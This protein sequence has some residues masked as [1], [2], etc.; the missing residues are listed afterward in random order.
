MPDPTRPPPLPYARQSLD[1]QDIESVSRIAASPWLTQ[2]PE[3]ECFEKE[4]CGVTGTAFAV[5]TS[6]GTAALHAALQALGVGPG[7]EVLVP[8]L[9]FVGTA[10]AVAACGATPVLVDIDSETLCLDPQAVARASSS[11]TRGVVAVHYGGNPADIDSIRDA[12]P[13]HSFILED[14]CHALGAR[15]RDRPAGS[16]GEAACF[17]F[18]PAKAITSAE[19]GAITSSDP[20][21]IARARRAAQHGIERS[22]EAFEGL[23][24]PAAHRPEEEGAWVY[25]QHSL[26]LNYRLSDLHAA[27]GRS[28]L[29]KLAEFNERRASI[30]RRYNHAFADLDSVRL[31]TE[32]PNTQSAWHL[33]PIRLELEVLTKSRAA[34]FAELRDQGLGVQVHYIPIHLQPYYRQ[35]LGTRWGDLPAAEDAYLRLISLPLFP[36]MSDSDVERVIATLRDCLARARR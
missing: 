12:L 15:Y 22:R 30:A 9:T 2:G 36:A 7:D 23:D 27:L 28:Q 34:I 17:S 16:L 13:N 20:S 19:G 8:T 29:C 11:R 33:Y 4:L 31:P 3:P 35:S 18:H 26:G 32:P 10:N 1:R 21:L 25:E 6:S 5:V 14:A 24:L